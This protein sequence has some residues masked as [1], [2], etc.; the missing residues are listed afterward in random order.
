MHL[1]YI[2]SREQHSLHMAATSRSVSARVAHRAFAKAYG[3]II[4]ASGF[5]HRDSL[6]LGPEQ[7]S[8][9]GPDA[10]LIDWEIGG[11]GAG[12]AEKPQDRLS[13]Q[14]PPR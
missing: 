14:L 12:Q 11:G 8:V 6:I 9:A 1:N 3:L 10:K 13:S 2:L 7:T 4:T 5:P